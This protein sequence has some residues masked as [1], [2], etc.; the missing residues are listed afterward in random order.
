MLATRLRRYLAHPYCPAVPAICVGNLVAGGAGKTPVAISLA[1]RLAALGRTPHIVLRG[2]GGGEPGPVRVDPAR[3][4]ARA[5]GDEALLLARV[6]PT[7][8]ARNRVEGVRSAEANG[9]G[10]IVL[11]DGLQNPSLAK[12]VSLVVVDGGYGFGNGRVIPAGPLR[13][14]LDEG[15]ARA[16]AVVLVGRDTSG[17][18]ARIGAR[19]PLVLRAR[20]APAA[21]LAEIAGRTVV[22]FAGIGRPDKFFETLAEID[23][24][25]VAGMPFPDHHEYAPD[26]IMRMVDVAHLHDAT[27]VTTAKDA[28]RLAP[29]ARAMVCVLEVEI[30]WERPDDVDALLNRALVAHAHG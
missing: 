14:T 26:E 25:V 19:V 30:A 12:D 20:L 6:A 22:A 11:D 7:W 17:A 23:C 8:V 3:H 27:L 18:A 2:Y 1:L 21:G 10:A 29:D 5:V 28:V 15:L 24:R 16:D 9:A 4:D 13:E